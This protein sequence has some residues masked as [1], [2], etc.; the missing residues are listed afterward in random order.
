LLQDFGAFNWALAFN[1]WSAHP[2]LA[3]VMAGKGL[4]V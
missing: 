1:D 3:A 2:P 4:K